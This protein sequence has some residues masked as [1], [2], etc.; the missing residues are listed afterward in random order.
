MQP[1]NQFLENNDGGGDLSHVA[2]EYTD[3]LRHYAGLFQ[4]LHGKYD[5]VL[6]QLSAFSEDKKFQLLQKSTKDK[7][8]QLFAS[9]NID[10]KGII[11]KISPDDMLQL[12]KSAI[13]AATSAASEI[14]QQQLQPFR[15]ELDGMK[16]SVQICLK[17]LERK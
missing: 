13:Q 6:S 14:A 3:L 5:F 9:S 10:K 1:L 2:Q 17:M 11:S 7:I 15:G 16:G 8:L 4:D 12:T